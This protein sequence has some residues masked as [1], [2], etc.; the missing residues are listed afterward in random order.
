MDHN[1]PFNEPFHCDEEITYLKDVYSRNHVS[2]NGYYTKMCHQ[3]FESNYH[4]KK[5]FLTTS[6][7]DALEMCALLLNIEK[8]DEVIMPS[9]TFV[10]TALAFV[11]QGA[12]IKFIDSRIDFPGMDENQI[13]ENISARTKAIVVV[14]YAGIACDMDRVMDIARR[15]G[16]YVIEDAAQCINGYY[17]S[18]PL[19][20]IGHFGC[21]SFHETKNVHCGEGGMLIINDESFIGRAEKIWEKGTNR[22][23]YFRNEVNKYEWVDTGSSFLPSD[24]LAAMLFAQLEKID[25]IQERRIAIWKRYYDFFSSKKDK[26][27]VII[28]TLP[29]YASNNGHIFWLVLESSIERDKLIT[30]LHEKSIHS[31]FHYQ[32]LH[33]SKFYRSIYPEIPCL[34]QSEMLSQCLLRLPLYYSLT[35]EEVDFIC[36]AIDNFFN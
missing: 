36:N 31:V 26:M 17:K 6:C 7:T 20:G 22:A 10:S 19:G 21:F 8:G 13:E 29:E 15:Y 11:R 33:A 3:F 9:F 24:I 25:V 30:H 4:F 16:L 2:G 18:K 32:S 23:E 28:P 12:T 27:G 5:C 34:S 35:N 1:I 14:H